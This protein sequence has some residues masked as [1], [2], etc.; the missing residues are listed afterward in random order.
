MRI[1]KEKPNQILH[2]HDIS[3]QSWRQHKK[4]AATSIRQWINP[5]QSG[6]IRNWGF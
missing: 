4:L 5:A 3:R 1:H 6:M 2:A